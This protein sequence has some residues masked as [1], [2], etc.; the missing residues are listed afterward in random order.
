M[1]LKLVLWTRAPRLFQLVRPMVDAAK[2]QHGAKVC[3]LPDTMSTYTDT[4]KSVIVL[5]ILGFTRTIR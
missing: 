3:N 4:S 1:Y 2:V 5:S